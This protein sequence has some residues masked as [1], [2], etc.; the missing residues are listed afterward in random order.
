MKKSKTKTCKALVDGILKCL[1]LFFNSLAVLCLG[2]I[3][4]VVL[5]QIIARY[6]LPQAPVWT[7]ELS[8]FLFIFS[9]V[10]ASATVIIK[11]RHVNLEL[12]HHRLSKKGTLI[13]NL[14]FNFLLTGFSVIIIPFAW[15]YTQVGS[16]QTSPAMTVNMSLI[17]S[18]T[19]I[20]FGLVA[21]CTILLI[22][23]DALSL[24]IKEEV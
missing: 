1:Q 23:R 21:L 22:L 18:S 17:F 9:I 6:A 7:E 14:F 5:F 19:V 12:F 11:G 2:G 24:M 4:F 20:F 16:R 8:R 3:I 13:C 10:F 15:K